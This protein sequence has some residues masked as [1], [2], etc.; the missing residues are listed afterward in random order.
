MTQ[1]RL[2]V[3]DINDNRPTFTQTQYEVN[4]DSAAE[5]G[6]EILAVSASDLDQGQN[7]RVIYS[8]VGGNTGQLFSVHKDSGE[9]YEVHNLA[10]GRRHIG[11]RKQ[12][13]SRLMLKCG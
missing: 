11:A 8:L 3:T 6:T 10:N 4:V 2:S 7:G 9:F 5:I 13:N 1:V 12:S